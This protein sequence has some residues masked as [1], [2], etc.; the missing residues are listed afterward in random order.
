MKLERKRQPKASSAAPSDNIPVTPDSRA[1]SAA[2]STSAPVDKPA[3]ESVSDAAP[4]AV[5][6]AVLE[7]APAAVTAAVTEAV[8]EAVVEAVQ[9]A[10]PDSAASPQPHDVKFL[11]SNEQEERSGTAEGKQQQ[12]I[13][14]TGQQS[15]QQQDADGSMTA[16]AEP[17]EQRDM[18]KVF[19]SLS[20]KL[21]EVPKHEAQDDLEGLFQKAFH[22]CRSEMSPRGSSQS[23]PFSSQ[24]QNGGEEDLSLYEEA[25]ALS[26]ND[27]VILDA[28]DDEDERNDNPAEPLM[29]SFIGNAEAASEV[30][31]GLN[32]QVS[33]SAG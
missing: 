12:C 33:D 22:T 31:N 20:G 30:S 13:V 16:H 2:V 10:V 14:L 21:P 29:Q 26:Q 8:T 1:D 27:G 28:S 24:Q 5:T 19:E 25:D 18:L 3:T 15:P 4:T 11:A 23:S 7:A 6:E 9:E 17:P 32:G